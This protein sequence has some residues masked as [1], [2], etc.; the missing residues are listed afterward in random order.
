[1][2]DGGIFCAEGG[3][4][5]ARFFTNLS[6]GLHA[7]AQP[8]TILRSSVAASAAPGV[9]ATKQ[10]R[11]LDLS[12][13]QIERACSLFECL[14]D[15]VITSVIKADCAPID[16]A[17]LLATVAKDQRAVLLASGIELRVVTP[18]GLPT[19]MGDRNRALQALSAALNIAASVS[20]TGD[21]VELLISTRSGYVE[22]IVR[23]DR[24]HG[25]LLNSS[26][27]LS[28]SLAQ[29]NILSQR[30]QY[31]YAEDPFCASMTLPIQFSGAEAAKARL[32]PLLPNNLDPHG[33]V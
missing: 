28:L 22:L 23:N 19:A 10:R 27:R 24:V 31:E 30:G 14:Q 25:R 32:A 13:Q 6:E 7:M 4:E 12:S 16:L 8:L 15:L 33:E 17:E 21:V 18:T 5:R 2:L 11:Y 29:A 9:D 3:D 20:A 1:M 26:E